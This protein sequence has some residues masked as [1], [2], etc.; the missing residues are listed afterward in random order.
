MAPI[1]G[2]RPPKVARV[3][4][5]RDD[6]A[7][8]RSVVLELRER[9]PQ[10]VAE[11]FGKTAGHAEL[12]RVEQRVR[13]VV[14]G[15]NRVVAFKRSQKVRVDARIGLQGPRQELVDVAL[16][17]RMQAAAADVGRLDR[18]VEPNLALEREV[19]RPGLRVPED[20]VLG[21]YVLGKRAAA[22]AAW[23]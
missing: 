18:G 9:V 10:R 19:P 4:G 5:V 17:L 11:A 23:T 20:L 16:P 12:E 8:G 1:I 22:A 14:G 3:V 6:V 7:L 2:R 21:R 13:I 15:A